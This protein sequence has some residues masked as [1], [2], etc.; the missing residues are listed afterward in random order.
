MPRLHQP[1]PVL[2]VLLPNTTK[3][4][5]DSPV[6]LFHFKLFHQFQTIT[7]TILLYPSELWAYASQLSHG[8]DF[9]INA[10]LCV[11]ARHLAFLRP[12]DPSYP[13]A[14][15][16]HLCRSLSGFRSALSD[17]LVAAHP[18]AFVATSILLQFEFWAN[19]D[20]ILPENDVA[21]FDPSMDQLF[22]FCS[23]LKQMFL[24]GFPP[25][26]V[27]NSVFMQ[28][29]QH[30]Y[31]HTLPP[32]LGCR[33]ASVNLTE[34]FSYDR[35]VTADLLSLSF[36]STNN[37]E[38][39]TSG[40]SQHQ[41]ILGMR[42]DASPVLKGYNYVLSQL[43]I[44]LDYLPWGSRD[45]ESLHSQPGL[46]RRLARH[47]FSFPIS[48]RGAFAAMMKNGD[49]HA[50][51]LLYHWYRAVRILLPSTEYWWASQRAAIL[52]ATLK[53]WL[54]RVSQAPSLCTK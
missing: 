21:L 1:V 24:R 4:A 39:A 54:T 27:H 31:E 51:L 48:C 16:S 29:I 32:A 47:I 43:C 53:T 18:D 17:N 40:Q 23:S 7:S 6:N 2:P 25:D 5:S 26:A 9:L 3:A 20:P 10:I 37:E 35:P 42:D 14:A 50:L 34:F 38:G 30:A 8:F 36:L 44:I 41:T 22:A 15:V 49:P 45:M 12:N 11:A 19:T 28:H 13:T 52:E 46:I 33:S